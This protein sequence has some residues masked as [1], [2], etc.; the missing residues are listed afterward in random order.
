MKVVVTAILESFGGIANVF[1]VIFL[2]MVMLG[3][4]GVNLMTNK[5]GYCSSDSLDSIYGVNR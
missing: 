1:I 2:S 4:I 5:L 3:V